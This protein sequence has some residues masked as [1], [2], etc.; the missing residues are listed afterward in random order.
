MHLDWW[1]IGLQTVNFAILVWLLHRFLYKPVLHLI[2]NR[3]AE[4]QRQYDDAR[5]VE[6]EAKAQLAA[7]E[8][9]RAGISAEREAALKAAAAQAQEM[10]KARRAQAER[11]AQALLDGTR[12]TLASERAQ[13]LE[14]CRRMALDLGAEFAQRLL[15]EVPMELRV[16][17]WIE[18]IEQHIA[19][20]AKSERDA[21]VQQLAGGKSLT[22][23]TA[24]PLSAA[25]A[26]IW[27]ER[28]RRPLGVGVAIAFEANPE[29]IAGAELHFP[30]AVL[31]F[32]WQSALAVAR[33]EVDAHD[34]R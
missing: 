24:A 32:S 34:P 1:T 26:D 27:R 31:R 11:D 16:E 18:R 21:L 28:L 9:E 23:I 14:D 13:A 19:G 8:A 10:A 20:L 12:K 33:S 25:T 4:V 15:A 30:T 6:D 29:L 5:T 2:D 7:V 17:A 3:K 22:V